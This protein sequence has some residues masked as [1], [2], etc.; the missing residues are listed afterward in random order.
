MHHH[1]TARHLA[2][3]ATLLLPRLTAQQS[4]ILPPAQATPPV[5]MANGLAGADTPD[6]PMPPKALLHRANVAWTPVPDGPLRP[7]QPASPEL[8]VDPAPGSG[9]LAAPGDFRVFLNT[10]GGTGG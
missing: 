3:L 6:V 1:H 5:V 2:L 4:T 7:G 8:Q 10:Q 9:V